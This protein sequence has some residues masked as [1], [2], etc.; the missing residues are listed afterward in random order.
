MCFCLVLAAPETGAGRVSA[1]PAPSPAP[2]NFRAVIEFILLL[3][4]ELIVS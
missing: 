4:L 3:K 2:L 1:A